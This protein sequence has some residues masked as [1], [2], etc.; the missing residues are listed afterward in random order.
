MW[1][2]ILNGPG[3][4]D[5]P[6]V[7]GERG[8]EVGRDK[9]NP[10]V[11]TGE[12][13]SRRHGRFEPRGEGLFFEDLGSR[14]GTQLNGQRVKGKVPLKPGDT[15]RIGAFALQVR[16][17]A[18]LENLELTLP[19]LEAG[20]VRRFRSGDTRSRVLLSRA[21]RDRDLVREIEELTVGVLDGEDV[22]PAF[23]TLILHLDQVGQVTS[24]EQAQRLLE[25]AL[26]WML[27]K[28]DGACGAIFL[29]HRDGLMVPVVARVR[30]GTPGLV[31]VS[32]EVL[33]ATL[34]ARKALAFSG[35]REDTRS[36]T[37]SSP[38]QQ[39][40]CAALGSGEEP[41]GALYVTRP[42]REE[43][44]APFLD[45]ANAVGCLVERAVARYGAHRKAERQDRTAALLKR[46]HGPDLV[47]A[48]LQEA[49]R[50]GVEFSPR[51]ESK[52]LGVLVA[53][54]H[55]LEHK[56]ERLAPARLVHLLGEL[57]QCALG[58]LLSFEAT[59]ERIAEGRVTALFGAP[60]S[61]PDDADR[62]VQ[63]ALALREEWERLLRRRPHAERF[64]L[65][66]GL[67]FGAALVGIVGAPGR[68]DYAALGEVVQVAGAICSAAEPGQI[69]LTHKVKRAARGGVSVVPVETPVALP[70]GKSV[71]VLL[72]AEQDASVTGVTRRTPALLDAD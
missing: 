1:Q 71:P 3:R 6:F 36:S 17:L 48:E 32:T 64:E 55:G 20:G 14:N 70:N 46:H 41:L 18:R 31:P 44:I 37:G 19:Q 21:R 38:S 53:E 34:K 16:R 45:L 29:R 42:D 8:V 72:A 49:A 22:R 39:V 62:M 25:E 13:V 11:L 30:S 63:A 10:I 47:R 23:G 65:R 66:V 27:Q 51:L 9:S 54:L 61:H 50:L 40:L 43:E 60:V 58:V 28:V 59:V 4:I 24:A 2:I 67:G 7:V 52:E 56:A 15:L 33:T 57:Y 5:V 68:Y 26:D 69:V 12:P 35:I